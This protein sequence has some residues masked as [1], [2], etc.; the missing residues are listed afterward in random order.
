[1]AK[2]KVERRSVC[3]RLPVILL[4]KCEQ[5]AKQEYWTIT[6]VFREAVKYYL[7]NKPDSEEKS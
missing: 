3:I 7:K 6:D 4:E 5:K 2:L 1:M